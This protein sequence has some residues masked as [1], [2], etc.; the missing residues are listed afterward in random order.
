MLTI[1]DIEKM[2]TKVQIDLS[3]VR[4]IVC[5]A[6]SYKME[7]NQNKFITDEV[8]RTWK[9][10]LYACSAIMFPSS[11]GTQW[12]ETWH[13][14]SLQ[15][16]LPRTNLH[17]FTSFHWLNINVCFSKLLRCIVIKHNLIPRICCKPMNTKRKICLALTSQKILIVLHQVWGQ[18]QG[19][20]GV[21]GWLQFI[22]LWGP[23]PKGKSSMR[24]IRSKAFFFSRIE[25]S[26][27]CY[28]DRV[29]Q[30]LGQV[31][32]SKGVSSLIFWAVLTGRGSRT[33]STKLP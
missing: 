5:T 23:A 2:M 8:P 25:W 20:V 33:C 14:C 13:T 17:W 10:L 29:Q 7:V 6:L 21:E 19:V 22:P 26:T 1:P 3:A 16:E 27:Q 31:L 24:L 11:S 18:H 15:F 28:L 30:A 4:D 32:S 12:T 9:S